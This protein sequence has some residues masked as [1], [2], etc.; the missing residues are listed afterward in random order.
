MRHNVNPVH[1][2]I[3]ASP[4]QMYAFVLFVMIAHLELESRLF[5]MLCIITLFFNDFLRS[6]ITYYV[7]LFISIHEP[8]GN[9]STTTIEVY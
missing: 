4:I 8:W 1:G 6:L 2:S 3:I 9:C 7:H 5:P